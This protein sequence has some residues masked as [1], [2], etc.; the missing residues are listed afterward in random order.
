MK[1]TGTFFAAAV[2][3]MLILTS[4]CYTGNAQSSSMSMVQDT[5]LK[6]QDGIYEGQSRHTYTEEPYWGKVRITVEG[7]LLAGVNFMIR[8]SSLHETFTGKYKKHYKGNPEYIKQVKNDWKGVKTYPN[9]LIKTQDINKI[10]AMSGATW[11]Y[12]IFKA[13]TLE[14]LKKIR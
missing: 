13:S 6:Y 12:N 11:S 2:V 10:D 8:D 4:T 5:L 3:A 7:G 14:A 9:K 1:K